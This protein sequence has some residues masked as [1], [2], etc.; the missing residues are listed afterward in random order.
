MHRRLRI[1]R[2]LFVVAM[3]ATATHC[4]KPDAAANVTAATVER[5]RIAATRVGCDACHRIGESTNTRFEAAAPLD[6]FAQRRFI[7]GRL[8]NTHAG[9]ARWIYNPRSIKPNTSMPRLAITEA[10]ASDIAAY[11]YSLH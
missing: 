1:T 11:L 7:A 10:E 2:T 3:A 9:L 4:T 5:G 8:P 6:G